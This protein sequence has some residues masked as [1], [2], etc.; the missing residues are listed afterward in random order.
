MGA[1]SACGGI[2]DCR[3]AAG[4]RLQGY[5]IQ[6]KMAFGCAIVRV[7]FAAGLAGPGEKGRPAGGQPQKNFGR[8]FHPAERRRTLTPCAF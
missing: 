8:L 5:G 4:N 7:A 3:L 2:E 6:N 1:F